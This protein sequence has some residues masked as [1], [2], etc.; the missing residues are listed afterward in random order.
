MELQ[1][2]KG[3]DNKP[4]KYKDIEYP[5]PKSL[6]LPKNYYTCLCVGQTGTGKTASIVKLLKYYEKEKIFTKE[7]DLV[8]QRIIL[9][10]PTFQSNTIW[11][12]LKNLDVENDVHEEDYTN[13]MFQAILDEV[14]AIREEAKEYQKVLKIWKKFKKVKKISLLTNSEVLILQMIDFDIG[15]LYEPRYKVAPVTHIILDDLVC[16]N[17]FRPNS[18]VSNLSVRNRHRGINLF[19]LSQSAKQITKIIRIQ[20]RLLMLYRFNSK[21]ICEDLFEL[22]SNVFTPEQFESTYMEITNE[23]YQFMCIDN[24][25]SKIEIKKNFDNLVVLENIKSFKKDKVKKIKAKE[26]P[27]LPVENKK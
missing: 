18:L 9:L 14:D 3:R 10:S 15:N 8:D 13:S 24:T 27:C 16:S 25:K 11:R 4:I 7:G 2:I 23:P 1:A 12:T 26:E 22:V 17:A 21:N 5:Q 19:I 20:A 6:D